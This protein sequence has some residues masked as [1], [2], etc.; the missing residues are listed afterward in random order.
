[1]LLKERNL[2][3]K[4][5]CN[6][7]KVNDITTACQYIHIAS[8]YSKEIIYKLHPKP[9]LGFLFFSKERECVTKDENAASYLLLVWRRG[10]G[11]GVAG[12]EEK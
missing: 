12:W 7:A 6:V 5:L 1:M 4:H 3:S 11:G 2:S 9:K 8:L 10:Q